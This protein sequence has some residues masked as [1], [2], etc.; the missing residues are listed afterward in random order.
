MNKNK[1]KKGPIYTVEWNPCKDEFI[2][3]Y[4]T[5]PAK[6]TL[7]NSKSEPIYDFG[8]GPRNEVYFSPH[9]NIVAI[10]GFGNLRGRLE[11]WNLS[12]QNKVPQEICSIQAD[13]TTYFEWSPDS[14][15]IL[16]G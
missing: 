5:M 3:I 11:I 8:T 14:E 13:D 6:A 7:F 12:T 9:G 16:T 2:A 10:C 1:G 4:G 15:H